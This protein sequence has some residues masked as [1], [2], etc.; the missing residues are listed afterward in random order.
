MDRVAQLYYVTGDEHAKVVMDRWVKWVLDNTK[1]GKDGSWG[2]PSTLKW[3]GQPQLDWNEKTQNWDAKDAGYNKT[4][5]VKVKDHAQDVGV[6]GALA[7]ALLFYAAKSGNQAPARLAKDLLD[8]VWK[9]YWTPKGVASDEVRMDYKRFGDP[10]FVPAG[11]QGVMPS[12]DRIEPGATFISLRS[13]YK[14]DPAWPKVEAFVKGGPAPRF[15]Y[16]RFWGQVDVAL[17]NATMG[18]LYPNGISAAGKASSEPTGKAQGKTRGSQPKAAKQ[19]LI[20]KA[21]GGLR[22]LGIPTVLAP[23]KK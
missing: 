12:G 3:S 18:Q 8:R 10:V 5:H 22:K 6:A 11:W 2:V 1:V 13:K 16:H 23:G 14:A 20:P 19:Q 15:S 9:K 21:S 17:A 7:R 4:L